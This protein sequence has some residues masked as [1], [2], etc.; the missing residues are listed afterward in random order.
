[1][2]IET[3]VLIPTDKEDEHRLSASVDSDVVTFELDGKE[4]FSM[5]FEGNFDEFVIAVMKV[6]GGWGQERVIQDKN[7][8]GNKQ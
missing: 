8:E 3:A 4:I 2:K 5:D 6:W 7:K 1:M